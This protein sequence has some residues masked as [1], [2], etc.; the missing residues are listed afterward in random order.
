MDFFNGKQL[1]GM[2]LISNAN[3]DVPVNLTDSIVHVPT[4]VYDYG[5]LFL[6][7]VYPFTIMYKASKGIF[8]AATMVQQIH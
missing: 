8:C 6:M 5:M 4:D 2:D 7:C 1:T 3:F